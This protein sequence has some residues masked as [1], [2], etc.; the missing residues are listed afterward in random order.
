[1]KKRFILKQIKLNFFFSLIILSSL[2]IIISCKKTKTELENE[3]P[4][5]KKEELYDFYSPAEDNAAWVEELLIRLEEERIA[6]EISKMEDSLSE[7]Q[8]ETEESNET[9][10][11]TIDQNEENPVEQKNPVEEFFEN[12]QEGKVLSGKNNEM[13]FYEFDNEILAPQYTAEGL[14][15]VH[16]ADGNVIRQFYDT[17]YKLIKK[18][19]WKITTVA[20]AK[21]LR[22]E[23]FIYSNETGKVIQKNI[24]AGIY[25]TGYS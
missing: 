18:E 20:D 7:Y 14:V 25:V 16:S 24:T 5:E 19:E 6:E 1:M 2:L 3:Q 13:R 21:K 9:E 17:E 10:V 23:D 8:L 4:E 12:M 22:S 15:I 11:D